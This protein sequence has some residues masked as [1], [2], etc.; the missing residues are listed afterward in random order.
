MK[1]PDT[2]TISVRLPA[3]RLAALQRLAETTGQPRSWHMARALDAYLDVQAWQIAGIKQA[4][5][6]L[7]AGRGIPHEEVKKMLLRWGKGD[8]MEGGE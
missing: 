3:D 4:I 7:D 6:E 5:A 2:K 1:K 8:G